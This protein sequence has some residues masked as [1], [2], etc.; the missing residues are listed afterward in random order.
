MI[1]KDKFQNHLI[2]WWATRRVAAI[3]KKYKKSELYQKLKAVHL[4]SVRQDLRNLHDW[5]DWRDLHDLHDLHDLRNWRNL[6]DWLDLH[7]WRDLHDWLDLHNLHDLRNLRNLHDWRNVRVNEL[8][9]A[10]IYA[11]G[12]K[13]DLIDKELN[14]KILTDI[15]DQKWILD[16][17]TWHG[18]NACGT[19][20]CM[21]GGT[22]II[23][24]APAYELESIV[25]TPTAAAII[26]YINTGSIPNYYEMDNEKALQDIRERA[27]KEQS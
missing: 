26:S 19:T 25:G 6:R 10:Y 3:A 24:G 8:I 1:D 14:T 21:A 22:I 2:Y 20:H 9:S 27:A 18:E 5:R 17:S 11:G 4:E 16:Q 15:E 7:D 13:S 12:H 23:L